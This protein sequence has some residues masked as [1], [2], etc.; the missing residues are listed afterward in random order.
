MVNGS[1]FL[2]LRGENPVTAG[3]QS[4]KIAGPKLPIPW[5]VD[6]DHGLVRGQRDF[7]A[8]DRAKRPDPLH[9][10]LQCAAAGRPDL[11]VM[12]TDK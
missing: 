1:R 3:L 10:A 5:C 11:H 9:R 12:T 8:L 2:L 6:F 4:D 7:G